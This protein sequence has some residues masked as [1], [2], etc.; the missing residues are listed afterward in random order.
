M[1]TYITEN[2]D[3]PFF[4]LTEDDLFCSQS[5]SGYKKTAEASSLLSCNSSSSASRHG[6]HHL[7]T[8]VLLCRHALPSIMS[9]QLMSFAMNDVRFAMG[10]GYN[11]TKEKDKLAK[12]NLVYCGC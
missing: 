8:F 11:R 2:S 10:Q 3:A 9:K 6:C 5:M 4:S 7:M 1:P 12:A